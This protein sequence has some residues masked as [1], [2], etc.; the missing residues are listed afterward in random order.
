MGYQAFLS[1]NSLDQP[2]V[3][4][5]AKRLINKEISVFLDVWDLI[6]GTACQPALE[7][8]LNESETCV[9]F[10]GPSGLG[11]WQ[12]EEMHAAISRRVSTS[13]SFRVIP[14]VLPGG[15][16][17]RKS[18]L[19]MFLTN[20]TWVEFS[21]GTL[22]DDQV[23]HRLVSGIL[24]MAPGPAPANAL[25]VG[26]CP[27]PGLK[28][29]EEAD[30]RFFFGRDSEVD[31][32]VERLTPNLADVLNENRFVSVIGASGS[33]KSSLVR[34]GLVPAL[35]S[36]R[37]RNGKGI[38]GSTN[39]P[40]ILLRPGSEPLKSLADA[41]LQNDAAKALLVKPLEF[42]DDMLEDK[43]TLHGAV[44]SVLH[45]TPADSRFVIVVDQFEELFTQFDFRLAQR[46]DDTSKRG[47]DAQRQAFINNLLYATEVRGGRALVI[48]TMRADFYSRC[49]GYTEL[50]HVLGDGQ[51][52]VPPLHEDGLRA[53]IEQPAQLCGFELEDGLI[54]LLVQD[55]R[56][57]PA[58]ALPL[59]QH[60][61][62]LL[63]QQSQG[64]RLRVNSY[65]Q[66]GGIAGAL[67]THANH[68]Y[69]EEL[70]D[71]RQRD[72]CRGIMLM[73]TTLGEGTEDTTRRIPRSLLGES[74]SVEEV[75]LRL[76]SGR[77]ITIS[78]TDPP[79]IEV[80]HEALIRGWGEL[81][82]WLNADRESLRTLHQLLDAAAN[83]DRHS[84]DG[85]YLYT[86][87][88]LLQAEEWLQF[89]SEAIESWPLAM[90]FVAQSREG[91]AKARSE[92]EQL[93]QAAQEAEKQRLADQAKAA[94]A[95]AAVEQDKTQRTRRLL[96]VVAGVAV[97]AVA[98]AVTALLFQREAREAAVVA[99]VEL[100]RAEWLSYAAQIRSVER[101]W[102]TGNALYAEQHLASTREDF[103]GWEFG[104]LSYRL[105]RT[106][107]GHASSVYSLDF[108]PDGRRIV[109]GGSVYS[110]GFS[111]DGGRI[112][113]GGG[114][115]TVRVWEA[116][117]GA[118]VLTLTG[119]ANSVMSV[120]FSPDGQRIV[121]GSIDATVRVW[122]ASTGAE[123]LT[124]TG[125][126]NSVL[127]VAFSADGQ[128]I[129]SGGVDATVRVWEAF[130]GTQVLTLTGHSSSV[131]DVGFS[132]D[133]QRIVGG[134]VD[135][136][137]RVWEASTGEELLTLTGHSGSVLSVGFSPDGRQ[138][139]SGGHDDTVRVWEA[140]TG[141]QVLTLTGHSSGVLSVGFSPDGQRIVSGGGGDIVRV[142]K[143]STGEEVLTLTGHSS[144]VL[145]VGFSPD[146]H[147]I[148]SGGGDDIVRVWEARTGTQVLTL[149]EHCGSVLSVGFSPDGHRIVSGSV[150]ATVRVWEAISGA[151]VLTLAGHSNDVSS[152]AFSPDGQWIVSGSIDATVTVWE[153]NTGTQVL[154]FT[155]HPGGV[156]SVAFSPDGH[157]IISG[158][159]DDTVGV[160]EASTGEKVKELT[161]HSSSVLSVAFSPDG[162]WIVSGG[163]DGTVRVWEASTGLEVF[164][165][166]GHSSSV[167]SVGFSPDGQWI[168]SG[169]VDATV[170]VWE[171]STGA[172]RLAL[173][174]HSSGVY[175]VGFSPDGRRIVS[176][177][178]DETVRVWEAST[179]TE[180]LTLA[181]HS[182]SVHSVAFSADGQR[183][184]SGSGDGTVKVWSSAIQKNGPFIRPTKVSYSRSPS[185]MSLLHSQ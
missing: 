44:G 148:V 54:D 120:G 125:H 152:V 85:S 13:Q 172:Q 93:E 67:E 87:S 168:A 173:A 135:G 79:Q 1:Y 108:S 48:I 158:G 151:Q 14:V 7:K 157:R 24:G 138:I 185:M 179:G 12:T 111:P 134:S 38:P 127:S 62:F 154:S 130:N 55:M 21:N 144:S 30:A 121:S 34:A 82:R 123:V 49:A 106:L 102:D 3:E 129:V 68:V 163:R 113:S 131:Y 46:R 103:R 10:I 169:S 109:S 72:V 57:Q 126:S 176:G 177:S 104:H 124:L 35:K 83:W 165:L 22:D 155:G 81:R 76:S 143:A 105:P 166:T 25:Y 96:G 178:L 11:P 139:V 92:R 160:W 56:Q 115:D 142:W 77:L 59:L 39:W 171:A 181:G 6:P 20:S 47:L 132:P 164:A 118:E 170:R 71:D 80:A 98:A 112:V 2:A 122:E 110:V 174:G 89:Q 180:V 101:E 182:S 28:A 99:Q 42:A 65:R 73:L 145:S 18:T 183:I 86:G 90:E 167:Y 32:L 45:D 5:L 16:R 27:Y 37:S 146:G 78:E 128:R 116:S 84:R 70:S 64:A 50:C 66:I 61:L 91:E 184:V 153:A 58:G 140:N 119:H 156:L 100:T 133:G 23:F 15:Q 175:S 95:V 147:R 53:A 51:D 36:G 94:E 136:T 31:W 162:R 69:Q 117:T 88:R 33:G 41:L 149:T 52:L 19:P 74:E 75:L 9:V 159:H 107:T 40:I 141:A 150:D 8:A 137:V 161:G 43:R 97:L 4:V 26:E 114:D 63:W 17:Q 29:F 60:T